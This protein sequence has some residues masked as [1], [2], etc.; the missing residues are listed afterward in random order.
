MREKRFLH[1]LA[2]DFIQLFINLTAVDIWQYTE[3]S[4]LSQCLK[5]QEQGEYAVK[6][7][8]HSDS[9]AKS[10]IISALTF[11]NAL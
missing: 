10:A 1:P 7:A 8:A 11:W 6:N 4:A 9:A 5:L 2:D 3:D